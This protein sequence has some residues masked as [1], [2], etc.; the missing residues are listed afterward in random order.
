MGMHH[1]GHSLVVFISLASVGGKEEMGVALL[2]WQHGI[3]TGRRSTS[4]LL[5]TTTGRERL[6]ESTKEGC[7]ECCHGSCDGCQ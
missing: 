7:T 2:P 4:R 1:R 5:P 6:S 3:M